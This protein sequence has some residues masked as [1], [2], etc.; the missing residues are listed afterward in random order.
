MSCCGTVARYDD[1]KQRYHVGLESGAYLIK[2]ANL[3]LQGAVEL[4]LSWWQ[5]DEWWAWAERKRWSS[6]TDSIYQYF[7][8]YAPTMSTTRCRCTGSSLALRWYRQA[9]IKA[10]SGGCMS[11]RDAEIAALHE[12]REQKR[13][14]VYALN[15]LLMRKLTG[16]ELNAP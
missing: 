5:S 9:L 2:E 13:A 14:E 1:S 11:W 12:R 16:R 10:A 15:A 7:D 8:S 4:T 3:R 6:T